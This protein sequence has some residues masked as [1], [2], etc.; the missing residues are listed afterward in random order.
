MKAKQLK[1]ELSKKPDVN[2]DVA[3]N[4][5]LKLSKADVTEV[6]RNLKMEF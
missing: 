5:I 1:K 3:G 2:L 6:A 4:S